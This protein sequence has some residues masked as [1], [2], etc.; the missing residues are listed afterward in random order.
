[1]RAPSAGSGVSACRTTSGN[2]AAMS[3]G[4]TTMSWCGGPEHRGH[5]LLVLALVELAVGEAQR[6]RVQGGVRV[7]RDDGG[8][9]GR[10]ETTGQVRPDRDVAAEEPQAGRLDDPLPEG[11]GVLLDVLCGLAAPLREA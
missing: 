4:L 8:G 9:D 6:E 11:L 3:D 7:A 1:M 2:T 5:L 10:V